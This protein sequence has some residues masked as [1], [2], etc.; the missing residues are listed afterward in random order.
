MKRCFG[1]G[2]PLYERY[3]DIEWG[4]PSYE[5]LYLFE[6]LILEGAQA[7]L[8]WLTILQRREGY[9]KAFCDFD[10]KLVAQMNDDQ[11]EALCSDVSI[12]RNRRKI[13]SVRQN[14]R[15]FLNIQEEF[16][17]FS[18][19]LWGFVDFQPIVNSFQSLGEVP[20]ETEISRKISKDLKKRGMSF[21]GPTIMYA[22]MQAVGMVSDHLEGCPSKE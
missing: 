3:H 10:P 9:K 18:K 21:V 13:F 4:K 6:M 14:A 11:L 19:Y 5:D 17:S 12:I 7:G 20:T 16:G 22:Y 15:F 8:N 1:E 2:N